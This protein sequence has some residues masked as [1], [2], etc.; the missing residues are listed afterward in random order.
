ML[1][2]EVAHF[3]WH[4]LKNKLYQEPIL[5]YLENYYEK[6]DRIPLKKESLF[7]FLNIP[8]SDVKV[9]VFGEKPFRSLPAN[10]NIPL[11]PKKPYTSVLTTKIKE[12]KELLEL[13]NFNEHSS[14]LNWNLKE[15]VLFINFSL[16]TDSKGLFNEIW[17]DFIKTLC[18]SLSEEFNPC[19]WINTEN[20]RYSVFKEVLSNFKESFNIDKYSLENVERIPYSPY[21]NYYCNIGTMANLSQIFKIINKILTKQNKK[22]ILWN[23]D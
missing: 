17:I 4:F 11:L 22:E 19:I 20:T 5:S 7:T 8:K 15:G 16:D 6:E 13:P 1:L 18:T 9:V 21:Y 2:E 14:F 12:N 3:S 10:E 23:Q